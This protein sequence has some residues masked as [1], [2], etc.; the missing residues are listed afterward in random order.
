[1]SCNEC[2]FCKTPLKIKG[3]IMSGLLVCTAV[4]T[5]ILSFTTNCYQIE[6]ISNNSTNIKN[7]IGTANKAVSISLFGFAIV[8]AVF[9]RY[10]NKKLIDVENEADELRT[11]LA[12]TKAQTNRTSSIINEPMDI[13]QTP[14]PETARSEVTIYPQTVKFTNYP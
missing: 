6:T 10:I 4:A 8:S 14:S 9:E 12:I 3:M 11:E 1:M 7:D 5:S 2:L 13:L